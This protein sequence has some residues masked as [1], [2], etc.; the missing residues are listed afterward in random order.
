MKKKQAIAFLLSAAMTTGVTIPV[1]ANDITGHWAQATIT[2]WQQNG[3]I[4]G[5]QDGTFQ[6]DKSITRAEFLLQIGRAHV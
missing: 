4:D 5:Y 1:L 3:K 6:P 2:K